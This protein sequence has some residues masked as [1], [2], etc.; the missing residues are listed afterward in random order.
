MHN[1]LHIGHCAGGVRFPAASEGTNATNPQRQKSIRAFCKGS[2]GVVQVGVDPEVRRPSLQHM[3]QHGLQLGG[4]QVRESD[5]VHLGK[6]PLKSVCRKITAKCTAL[7]I[8]RVS[9][10]DWEVK[11][12]TS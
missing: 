1:G 9:E 2:Q 3:P 8:C 11:R 5:P 4:V 12:I 10:A 6:F 7:L